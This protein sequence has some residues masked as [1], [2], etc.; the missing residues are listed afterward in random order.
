[1]A[2]GF[3]FDRVR[4]NLDLVNRIIPEKLANTTKRYFLDAF[5]SESWDGVPWKEVQ[6]RTSGT[7]AYNYP[8]KKDLGR[9]TRKILIGKG[10]GRLRRAVSISL[11]EV[12][13]KRI[14]FL[15]DSTT[16]PY[17][18]VHNYGQ[19]TGRGSGFQMPQRKFM[20]DSKALR[21]LQLKDIKNQIDKIW[22]Q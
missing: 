7:K 21:K 20:G 11:R 13:S 5:K 3:N 19:R 9:R 14:R 4:Q 16:I 18:S 8:K 6:R 15:V 17:A 22:K 1:M 10:S 12:N 2:E